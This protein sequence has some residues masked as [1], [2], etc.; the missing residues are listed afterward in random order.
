MDK[1]IVF[2]VGM[3]A[4]VALAALIVN[5]TMND[6]K[7][8][9]NTREVD[10]GF[11]VPNKLEIKVEDLRQDGGRETVLKYDGRAYLLT[12]DSNGV[13]GVVP[14]TVKPAEIIPRINYTNAEAQH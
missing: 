11:V 10:S 14:Y 13:P 7:V 5:Y 9:T 6:N 4:G 12:L 3:T 1:P 2:L 8:T